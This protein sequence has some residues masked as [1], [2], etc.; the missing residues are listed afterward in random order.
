VKLSGS[1]YDM[2]LL[3]VIPYAAD[4]HC[5]KEKKYL[6]VFSFIWLKIKNHK[7]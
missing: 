1:P 5:P 6:S 7:I 3:Q 2:G 4:L